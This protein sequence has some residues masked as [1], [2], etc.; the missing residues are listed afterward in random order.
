MST[1]ENSQ[2]GEYYSP[3][4]HEIDL[5]VDYLHPIVQRLPRW[6]GVR[7][8]TAVVVSELLITRLLL[9][10]IVKFDDVGVL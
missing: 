2:H 1:K 10:E 5:V 4:D 3:G 8:D 6:F 9:D 7:P